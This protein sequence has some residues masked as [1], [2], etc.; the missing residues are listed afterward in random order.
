MA[1]RLVRAVA[2]TVLAAFGFCAGCGLSYVSNSSAR[3]NNYPSLAESTPLPHHVPPHAGGVSL[4]FAMVHDALHERFPKHGRA[5]YEERNRLTREKLAPLTPTNPATFPLADDLGAELERLGRPEEAV[6]AIRDKLARQQ[7]RELPEDK[8]YTSY[9]NLGTFL[10]SANFQKATAGDADARKLFAEGVES[11]RKAIGANAMAHF[12]REQW[13]LALGEFHLAA[14]SA[15]DLLRKFDFLGNSLDLPIEEILDREGNWPHTGY[16]RAANPAFLRGEAA[17]LVP[18]YFRPD[19]QPDDPA[20]WEEFNPVRKFITKAGAEQGWG[21][22]IVPTHQKPVAF[23]EPVL[24]IIGMWRQGGGANPHFALALGETMLRVGQ[25]HIAWAAFER[26]ARL[27]DQFWPDAGLRDY[28]RTHCRK[29]Q[30]DIERS[31]TTGDRRLNDGQ[32]LTPEEVAA[33]RPRFEAELAHGQRYQ[34]EYQEFEAK[35]IA[36]GVPLDGEHFYDAFHAGREPIASPV[37]PEERFLWV[38]REKKDKYVLRRAQA[39]GMIGAG[40]FAVFAAMILRV[41]GRALPAESAPVPLT[42]ETDEKGTP[43]ETS[44]GDRSGA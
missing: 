13:Q 25:R 1:G 5:Y 7:A 32:L 28:L 43:G 19:A 20:R 6:A 30:A 9:A 42:P 24:G 29:R 18:G 36:A 34:R 39:W 2:V 27:A 41:R 3:H 40:L 44:E 31:L 10:M 23:D 22:A 11:I 33:F 21:L 16:G 14:M 12:G 8:L 38:P 26:A 4:R 15:P 35:Q 37:G 17:D